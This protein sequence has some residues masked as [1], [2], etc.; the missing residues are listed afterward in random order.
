[1]VFLE[2]FPTSR[3]VLTRT[4]K[5]IKNFKLYFIIK[6]IIEN[7]MSLFILES[8]KVFKRRLINSNINRFIGFSIISLMIKYSL[9]FLIHLSVLVK[10]LREVGNFSKKTIV[11]PK[12]LSLLWKITCYIS[13]LSLQQPLVYVVS[14]G[15]SFSHRH[16]C[17]NNGHKKK[18]IY[19]LVVSCAF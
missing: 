2:N 16:T 14:Y 9:N 3:R 4:D 17:S 6:L 13:S 19:S 12:K 18:L 8:I 15:L 5:W 10:T 1:M 11:I 7:P